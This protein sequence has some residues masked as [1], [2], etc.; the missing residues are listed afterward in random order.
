MV[1]LERNKS[2]YHNKFYNLKRSYET[3]FENYFP[4]TL[5]LMCENR[6]SSVTQFEH[7]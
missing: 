3:V 7:I 2:W 6:D 1:P 4:L 5:E